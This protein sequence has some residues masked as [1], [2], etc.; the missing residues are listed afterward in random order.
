MERTTMT[1]KFPTT[2]EEYGES[3]GGME[4][5]QTRY[6]SI[7]GVEERE[8]IILRIVSPDVIQE[9][10]GVVVGFLIEQDDHRPTFLQQFGYQSFAM[11]FR[12][13]G[14]TVAL[15]SLLDP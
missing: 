11:E 6:A 1:P 3:T 7:R 2:Q 4:W 10:G 8:N 14:S 12:Q 15:S 5:R 9:T 13:P